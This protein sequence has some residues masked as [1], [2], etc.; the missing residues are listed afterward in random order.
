LHQ[1][2]I[3]KGA[4]NVAVAKEFLIY[5]IEPNKTGSSASIPAT[6][7]DR[8][9]HGKLGGSDEASNPGAAQVDTEHVFQI[10]WNAIVTN[11]MA[12]EAAADKALKRT[13]EIF[14][15]SPIAQS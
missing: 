10:A 14:T 1:V 4:K 7:S 13:K 6:S 15:K 5:A 12:L 2:A 9:H 11:G 8:L 3:P